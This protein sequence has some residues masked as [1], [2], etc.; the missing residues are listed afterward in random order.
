MSWLRQCLS[1]LDLW[2]RQR[3][4][5]EQVYLLLVT[6]CLLIYGVWMWMLVPLQESR[7][8]SAQ[9]LSSAQQSLVAVE[10]LA[11]E[12]IALREQGDQSTAVDRL[13]QF[14]D[15]SAR[16]AGLT[17]STLEPAADGLSAS[18]RIENSQMPTV[19]GWL[20]ELES[21]A[22]FVVESVAATPLSSGGVSVSLRIRSRRG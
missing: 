18:L 20:A 13:P 5:R 12:L 7:T 3:S 8:L 14:L 21:T 17:V 11:A 19:L 2:F 6:A 1:A 4:R 9:R 22:Q 16:A 15:S 10:Q